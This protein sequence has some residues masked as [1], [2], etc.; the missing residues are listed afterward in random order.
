MNYNFRTLWMEIFLT[1]FVFDSK[2]WKTSQNIRKKI[3]KQIYKNSTL[4]HQ[5]DFDFWNSSAKRAV[6]DNFS[7]LV[8]LKILV[9]CKNLPVRMN[10]YWPF[11]L[12]CVFLVA[13]PRMPTSVSLSIFLV[14]IQPW[15]KVEECQFL[16]CVTAYRSRIRIYHRNLVHPIYIY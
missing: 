9:S 15:W 5:T 16:C 12:Y 10:I 13:M 2:L 3:W 1:F 6:M 7:I 8:L 14:L 11:W 4:Q